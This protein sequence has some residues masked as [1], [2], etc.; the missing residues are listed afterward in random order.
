VY[1]YLAYNKQDVRY[2]GLGEQRAVNETT[3]AYFKV[4][5]RQCPG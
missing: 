4:V 5:S 3:V 1:G 2:V